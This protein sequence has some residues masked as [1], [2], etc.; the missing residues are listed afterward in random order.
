MTPWRAA[1]R[2][3]H[4][5]ELRGTR[6][7]WA[8]RPGAPSRLSRAGAATP[9]RTNGVLSRVDGAHTVHLYFITSAD[10]VKLNKVLQQ[11][12]EPENNPA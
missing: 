8:R 11:P 9:A 3:Q 12:N 5:A 1:P 2:P 7:P 10:N 4:T 6:H